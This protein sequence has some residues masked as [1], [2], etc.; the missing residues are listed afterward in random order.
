MDRAV[1]ESQIPIIS[2]VGHETDFTIIDFVADLRAPTPSAAAELVI[3]ARQEVDEQLEVLHHRLGKALRDPL[4]MARQR[5][6]ELAQHR[7]FARITDVL[8]RRQ[9]KLD[10][11]KHRLERA[12][13]TM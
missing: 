8:N 6:T 9:Q 12:E 11:L 4:L 10:D 3:R 5:L 7:A 2:A 1:A 13:R